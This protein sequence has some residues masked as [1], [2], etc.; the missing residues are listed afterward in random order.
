LT[1]DAERKECARLGRVLEN[2]RRALHATLHIRSADDQY[3]KVQEALIQA[4]KDYEH[5]RGK[6]RRRGPPLGCGF[7][8][9][10]INA[11]REGFRSAQGTMR[12]SWKRLTTERNRAERTGARRALGPSGEQEEFEDVM[13]AG[14]LAFRDVVRVYAKLEAEEVVR[15]RAVDPWVAGFVDKLVRLA[16]PCL[17]D[18]SEQLAHGRKVSDG[19][20]AAT[21]ERFVA[22][23]YNVSVSTVRKRRRSPMEWPSLEEPRIDGQDEQSPRRALSAHQHAIEQAPDTTAAPPARPR[24]TNPGRLRPDWAD[25]H[26]DL[27]RRTPRRGSP[28]ER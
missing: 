3:V 25:D 5:A 6:Q 21:A 24:P 13:R 18:S 4:R 22:H 12:R 23:W 10:F 27:R 8:E 28:A 15:P 20:P 7:D 26:E 1:I 17:R 16:E 2:L 14:L 9:D 19:G 11:I